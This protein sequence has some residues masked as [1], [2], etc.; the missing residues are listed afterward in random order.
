M[1]EAQCKNVQVLVLGSSP[2]AEIVPCQYVYAANASAGYFKDKLSSQSKAKV[3]SVLSASELDYELR[4]VD[5]RKKNGY[6]TKSALLLSLT[7]MKFL[8]TE[9]IFIMGP[10]LPLK[11][12]SAN[13][14]FITYH[15]RMFGVLLS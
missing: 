11:D 2:L 8:F 3:T 1:I 15:L 14:K 6:L 5:S 9:Q 10:K 4:D 13:L 12:L 7:V